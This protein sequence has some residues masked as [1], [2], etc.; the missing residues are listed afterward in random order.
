MIEPVVLQA[1]EM[2]IKRFTEQILYIGLEIHVPAF[3]QNLIWQAIY[4]D[5]CR[6]NA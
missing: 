4:I 6:K 3:M 1:Y 2:R 5:S